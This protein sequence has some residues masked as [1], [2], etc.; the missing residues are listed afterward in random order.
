MAS[1]RTQKS[2]QAKAMPYTPIA[3]DKH[4]ANLSLKTRSDPLSHPLN[5]VV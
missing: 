3:P 1:I 5:E 4:K 2:T